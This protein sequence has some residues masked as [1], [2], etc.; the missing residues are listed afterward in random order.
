VVSYSYI[1]HPDDEN[2]RKITKFSRLRHTQIFSHGETTM[3]LGFCNH[4]STQ[5]TQLHSSESNILILIS[6][7]STYSDGTNYFVGFATFQYNSSW[8]RNSFTLNSEYLIHEAA[9]GIWCG[10]RRQVLVSICSC[11]HFHGNA[12]R[13]LVLCQFGVCPGR[14]VV[15]AFGYNGIPRRIHDADGY[16]CERIALGCLNGQGSNLVSCFE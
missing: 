9:K 14:T 13:C 8:E 5:A 10:F 15:H 2:D 1:S 12:R 16:R 6:S 7:C 4:F 11:A 3:V